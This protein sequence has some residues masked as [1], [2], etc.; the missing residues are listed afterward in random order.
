M[1]ADIP[2]LS[3]ELED[4]IDV[5]DRA[6]YFW[7]AAWGADEPTDEDH[8]KAIAARAALVSVIGQALAQADGRNLELQQELK[9]IA[10]W[11]STCSNC[12]AAEVARMALAK[13]EGR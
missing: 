1:T 11:S 6:S 12:D 13:A 2:K 10:E 7:G 3:D 9:N 8:N 5:L 4:A